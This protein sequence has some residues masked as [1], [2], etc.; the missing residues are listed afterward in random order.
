MLLSVAASTI[1]CLGQ[2]VQ[3]YGTEDAQRG[4]S[5]VE[6]ND[7]PSNSG[8][9]SIS[10]P[11]AGAFPVSLAYNAAGCRPDALSGTVGLGWSLQAGGEVTRV[12]RGIRDERN[13]MQPAG[14]TTAQRQARA[15]HTQNNEHMPSRDIILTMLDNVT[16][17]SLDTAPDEFRYNIIGRSGVFYFR[18]DGTVLADRKIKVRVSQGVAGS[19]SHGGEIIQTDNGAYITGIVITFEDGVECAF[20][21]CETVYHRYVVNP[22][23]TISPAPIINMQSINK[24]KITKITSPGQVVP[25]TFDYYAPATYPSEDKYSSE[26]QMV[27]HN[28]Y[29]LLTASTGILSTAVVNVQTIRGPGYRL[30][31]AYNPSSGLLE[32]V[33]SYSAAGTYL[34]GVKLSYTTLSTTKKLLNRIEQVYAPFSFTLKNNGS[35]R[36]EYNMT[37]PPEFRYF[38]MQD[39]FAHRYMALNNPYWGTS[40]SDELPEPVANTAGVDYWGFYNGVKSPYQ[41][42]VGGYSSYPSARYQHPVTS[43]SLA[44]RAPDPTA[45][46]A[47][48]LQ[49]ISYPTGGSTQYVYEN[50]DYSHV[51]GMMGGALTTRQTGGG[52][53]IRQIIKN[54]GIAAGIIVKT[55]DYRSPDDATLSSGVLENEPLYDMYFSTTYLS[56][57]ACNASSAL[58]LRTPFSIVPIGISYSSIKVTEADG[59]FVMYS[60]STPKEYP[61]FGVYGGALSQA[62]VMNACDGSQYTNGFKNSAYH[63]FIYIPDA[64]AVMRGLVQKKEEYSITGNL[65]KRTTY[66]FTQHNVGGVAGYEQLYKPTKPNFFCNKGNYSS[67]STYDYLDWYFCRVYDRVVA[68]PKLEQVVERSY[69]QLPNTAY[70][71]AKVSYEYNLDNYRYTRVT[72][73]DHAE[74]TMPGSGVT[75]VDEYYYPTNYSSN[76]LAADALKQ[77]NRLTE[78]LEQRTYRNGKVVAG[79]LNEYGVLSG[80]PEKKYRLE[81]SVPLVASAIPFNSSNFLANSQ[82]YKLAGEVV[83][84]ADT[85][86]VEA[87]KPRGGLPVHTLYGYNGLLPV[88]TVTGAGLEFTK[89]TNGVVGSYAGNLTANQTLFTFSVDHAVDI[90]VRVCLNA[91]SPSFMLHLENVSSGS[92]LQPSMFVALA[93]GSCTPNPFVF[94]VAPGQYRIVNGNSSTLSAV[95]T[96]TS[97]E[98]KRNVFYTSFED[99]VSGSIVNG[100]KTGTKCWQGTYG[101]NLPATYGTYIVSYWSGVG[102]IGSQTWTYQQVPVTVASNNANGTYYVGGGTNVF[103]DEVRLYPLG[104]V[105]ATQNYQDGRGVS[106]AM[107]PNGIQQVAEYDE[108]GRV[109]L[110]RNDDLDIVQRNQYQ[111]GTP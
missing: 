24:W 80:M 110:V 41:T 85:K 106:H 62:Y 74:I 70:R 5:A 21:A 17:H 49:K 64:S 71:E 38:P 59:S 102:A 31:F 90:S 8:L 44:N 7:A 101:F 99:M 81:T 63:E 11:L 35:Y 104:A 78:V 45:T 43:L 79:V 67:A 30:E 36:F 94:T 10:V 105:M 34:D 89:I 86:R 4:N 26:D 111:M 28:G 109:K 98:Y 2:A 66:S 95:V 51:A 9:P 23:G 87:V 13:N 1:T 76:V 96:A 100:G 12:V 65:L 39:L 60:Y 20:N 47:L 93:N 22:N 33:N 82:Y 83:Y 57:I 3:L 42:L 73:R 61:G 103:V 6:S 88:A 16:E 40:W 56:G 75:I 107:S 97:S 72:K 92:R 50:N 55:Y 25:I 68:F 54:D 91:N 46:Q 14:I 29:T 84:N 77:A 15:T 52:L 69:D 19:F 37:Q 27:E 48:V 32:T 58:T 53:R 18:P 108:F